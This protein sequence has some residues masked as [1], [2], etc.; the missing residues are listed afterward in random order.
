MKKIYRCSLCPGV[1]IFTPIKCS[2]SINPW[3]GKPQEVFLFLEDAQGDLCS[4]KAFRKEHKVNNHKEREQLIS[5]YW[6][7]GWNSPDL[8]DTLI[9]VIN[10]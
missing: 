9:L 10:Y 7:A 5:T 4:F 6:N 8:V 3:T 1:Y 2:Q